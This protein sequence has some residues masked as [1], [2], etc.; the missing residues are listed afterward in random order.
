MTDLTTAQKN[1]LRRRVGDSGA[2][3]AFSDDELQ[4]A[5]DEAVESLDATTVILI[6]W[7]IADAAKFND[8]T[9][10]QTSEKKSQIFDH[11]VKLAAHYQGKVDTAARGVQVKIVGMRSVPP[12]ER[13]APQSDS[14]RPDFRDDA[15]A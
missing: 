10:G 13:D 12:R 4:D 15:N 8:F 1:T 9:A 6:E 5:F 14:T 3:Q 11:L 7:L 2:T